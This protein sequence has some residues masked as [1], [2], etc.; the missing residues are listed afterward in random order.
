[1]TLP[2]PVGE[3]NV[4]S[5]GVITS[6]SFTIN[7]EIVWNE[8]SITVAYVGNRLNGTESA[9]NALL[10]F[11]FDPSNEANAIVTSQADHLEAGQ[12]TITFSVDENA[13]DEQLAA[14]VPTIQVSD[15]AEYILGTS[16]SP[17]ARP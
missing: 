3:C 13:T 2:S 14:L 4:E 7:M 9:D 8:I 15:G 12:T 17:S 11:W 10:A 1:M 16:S 5:F 6:N